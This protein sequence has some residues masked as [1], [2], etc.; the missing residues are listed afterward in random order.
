MVGVPPWRANFA[1]SQFLDF[2]ERPEKEHKTD[3][4]DLT[5][6]KECEAFNQ[7]EIAGASTR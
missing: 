4:Q 3:L 2:Y 6:D 1:S 5:A 7:S